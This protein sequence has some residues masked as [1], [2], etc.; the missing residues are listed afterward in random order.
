[1]YP[2]RIAIFEKL[3]LRKIWQL[4]QILGQKINYELSITDYELSITDY[5]LGIT[6]YELRVTN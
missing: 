2:E 4:K 5:E 1:M 3:L 6:D